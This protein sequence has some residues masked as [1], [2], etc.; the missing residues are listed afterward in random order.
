MHYTVEDKSISPWIAKTTVGYLAGGFVWA[1]LT[2]GTGYLKS[3]DS[4]LVWLVQLTSMG[5]AGIVTGLLQGR[6]LHALDTRI[7]ARRWAAVTMVG[8]VLGLFMVG[9]LSLGTLALNFPVAGAAFSP[10]LDEGVVPGGSMVSSIGISA[11]FVLFGVIFA[12]VYGAWDGLI[13][14]LLQ[15]FVMKSY[16]RESYWWALINMLAIAA[17]G[18][19]VVLMSWIG[20]MA[21][22]GHEAIQESDIR[23]ASV[24]LL[25]W[26]AMGF[27]LGS[28]SAPILNWLLKQ[29]IEEGRLL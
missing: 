22:G 19:V 23:S 15:W 6:H 3:N 1:A 10:S 11:Y 7:P 18:A 20:G 4:R 12:S 25:V 26:G 16:V 28:L 17:A 8:M 29:P 13:V 24:G 5:V 21:A 9:V 27:V 14:G 2:I